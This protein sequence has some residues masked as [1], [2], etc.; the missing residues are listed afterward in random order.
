[1][2][3][4]TTRRPITEEAFD[5]ELVSTSRGRPQL[6]HDLLLDVARRLQLVAVLIVLATALGAL[7]Q[8]LTGGIAWAVHRPVGYGALVAAW[9]TSGGIILLARSGR[10]SPARLLDVGIAYEI[11]V[12]AILSFSGSAIRWF[13]QDATFITWS[14]IAVWVL[15]FPIIVPNT[16]G[17][18]ALA[19]FAAAAT[20]PLAVIAFVAL[21][22]DVMPGADVF[23]RKVWPNAVAAVLAIGVSRVVYRLGEQLSEARQMGSYHLESLLGKGGMGEVWRATHR[24][25]ARPAAVKL[26]RRDALGERDTVGA[27]RALRRFERE[28]KVT[29]SLRS[30]YTIELYDFGISQNG[31]FYY[32]MELLDGIDLQSLVERFGPQ[33]SGRVTRILRQ[34]CHSLNEA[35]LAGLVHRDIKPANIFLCRHGTDLDWAKVLD[36]GI[37]KHR[38]FG[39]KVDAQLTEVGAFTG[40]PAYM[41]PEMVLGDGNVDGRAD[42]YSLGCVGYWLL[43]GKLVFEGMN[44]MAVMAAHAHQQPKPIAERTGAA[45]HPGLA[46]LILTCL[47]KDPADRPANAAELGRALAALDVE[48]EWT[49]T[50]IERWWAGHFPAQGAASDA[51]PTIPA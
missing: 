37:V 10:L 8:E 22:R 20:E 13:V 14:P 47:A 50:D 1:M 36:F 3:K 2:T 43:T 21:G 27:E 45:V 5:F 7:V 48:R 32:V 35:H 12:A 33:P 40:T 30:P 25:L 41:P 23:I 34:A 38:A 16:T 18:T 19:S 15:I 28:A 9:L 29:A 26:I 42:L 46:A 31:T 6:P 11:V 4:P 51:A 17:R 44:P 24:M 49:E 39:G